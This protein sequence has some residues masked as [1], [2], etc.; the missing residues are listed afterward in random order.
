MA[1]QKELREQV[2]YY[3]RM[4]RADR[5]V[6]TFMHDYRNLRI[7]LQSYLKEKDAEMCI[8]DRYQICPVHDNIVKQQ[9]LIIIEAGR[10]MNR[11]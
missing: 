6:R 1:L 7:G 5:A 3:E 2:K 9:R 4:C 8:R 11:S 10:E